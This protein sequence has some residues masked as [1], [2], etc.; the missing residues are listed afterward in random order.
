MSGKD[1]DGLID[2]MG[3]LVANQNEGAIEP[4]QNEFINGLSCDYNHVGP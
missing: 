2:K 1:I 3:T 4:G